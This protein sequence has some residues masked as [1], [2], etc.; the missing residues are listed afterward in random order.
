MAVQSAMPLNAPSRAEAP[1][2]EQRLKGVLD[3]SSNEIGGEVTTHSEDAAPGYVKQIHQPSTPATFS[4]KPFG[5]RRWILAA[6]I[7]LMGGAAFAQRGFWGRRNRSLPS[8]RNGVPTWEV[9][10][11]FPQD[12]FTFARIEYDSYGGRGR[13]GGGCWTDYPDSDLNFSLRLQQ[14]TSLKVNPDPVVI[15]LTDEELFDYP[16]IYIIEPGGLVFSDAEVKALRKYCLN[17][18]FLMVDD[19]W[20]DSQYENLRS[21]LKR[22]FPDRDPF[23]VPLEH[24]IFHIVY[25]LKEKPQVPAIN[26][27][28]RG[29]DG[30][31]GSWEWSRD[32]SDTSV[33]HYR[34]ITDDEDRIMVFICHNTDLGDGWEREGEDQ[35]YFDEFSVKKAYPM[36]INIV[37]YAMTH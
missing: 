34:A 14:L 20:G 22:V 23:E 36:G 33:P 9:D 6:L 1:S 30:S 37:T 21:E 31:V 15:R 12:S 25:D 17:G 35:W 13:G 10:S 16:F 4:R 11:R 2:P 18:G 27:A 32:G 19:F 24:E 26:S 5:H 29:A 8:D 7:L 3:I 28:R